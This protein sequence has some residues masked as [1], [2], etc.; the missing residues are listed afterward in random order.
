MD[1]VGWRDV[2]TTTRY[3]DPGEAFG[4]WQCNERDA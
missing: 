1:H 4:E 2:R 3:V